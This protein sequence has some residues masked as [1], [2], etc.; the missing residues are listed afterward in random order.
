MPSPL[1]IKA[2]RGRNIVDITPES[3]GWKHVG[4]PARAFG[5]DVDDVAASRG[6]DEQW[7]WHV[8]PNLN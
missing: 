3:A 4:F 7:T 8:L 2:A 1:L 6:L 5:R